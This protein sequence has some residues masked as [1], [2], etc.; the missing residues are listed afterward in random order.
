MT[1]EIRFN[2]VQ[3]AII[4][5]NRTAAFRAGWAATIE[6]RPTNEAW[7]A[8]GRHRVIVLSGDHGYWQVDST[9]S[10]YYLATM[11]IAQNHTVLPGDH[12]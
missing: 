8:Y 10:L 11:W 6:K 7:R 9:R 2:I 12:R 4:Q 3:I 5:H 1:Y